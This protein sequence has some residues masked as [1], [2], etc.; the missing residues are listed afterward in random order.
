LGTQKR[1]K[2]WWCLD[3]AWRAALQRRKVAFFEIG[4]LSK[5]QILRRFYTR[6]VG[7]PRMAG[8]VKIPKKIVGEGDDQRTV[9]ATT[10]KMKGWTPEQA[11]QALK[12][13]VENK[14]KSKGSLMRI[15][16]HP[17]R[18]INMDG[19]RSILSGWEHQ[20]EWVPDVVVIDYADILAPPTGFQGESRDAVN[21]NWMAMRR[22]SQ[23]YH[24]LVITPTQAKATAFKAEDLDM[25]HFSE[26][27][28]KF[29]HVTGMFGL[30]QNPA[31][32]EEGLMRLNW[33]VLREEEFSVKRFV[34]VAQCL[35]LA[36]PSVIS[37][38]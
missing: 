27:S 1:G 19:I 22:L 2:T 8:E 30:N 10:K 32:K 36:C 3:F 5:G 25:E 16:T 20:D 9:R 31:Q 24:C 34:Y 11:R 35:G 13:V 37:S 23:E 33:L 38:F 4:D 28:R 29:S 18:S 14:V 12:D 15:E 17:T 21:E 7:L 6:A 26:D